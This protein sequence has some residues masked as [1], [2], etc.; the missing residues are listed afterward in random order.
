MQIPSFGKI[1]MVWYRAVMR[2]AKGPFM[3]AV[4]VRLGDV[5]PTVPHNILN[6]G[7]FL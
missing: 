6:T 5:L 3:T 4:V 7:A 2:P 1:A